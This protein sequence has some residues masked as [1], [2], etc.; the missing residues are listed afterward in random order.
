MSHVRTIDIRCNNIG[1]EGV[2]AIVKAIPQLK[3]FMIS[4]TKCTSLSASAIYTHLKDIEVLWC[5]Q[6]YIDDE[7]AILVGQLTKLKVLSFLG[8]GLEQETGDILK[9]I[10]CNK[11]YVIVWLICCYLSCKYLNIFWFQLNSNY[12]GS[13]RFP[14]GFEVIFYTSL[15]KD[16]RMST[17]VMTFT[18]GVFPAGIDGTTIVFVDGLINRIS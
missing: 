8:N 5:E 7:H 11:G 3:S 10:F 13:M 12:L 16:L 17:L 14:V 6:N 18:I 9:K 15:F 2:I 4:E 1:D